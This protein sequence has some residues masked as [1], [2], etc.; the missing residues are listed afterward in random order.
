MTAVGPCAARARTPGRA[1][2]A[3]RPC[4]P[5]RRGTGARGTGPGRARA[6]CTGRADRSSAPRGTAAAD[7]PHR[8]STRQ[9]RRRSPRGAVR[10]CPAAGQLVVVH[11]ESAR[12]AEA[13]RQDE[14]RDERGRRD[15]RPPARRSASTGLAAD[16]VPRV[17]V[18]AVAR[19][20]QA[21]HHRRVRR[22][23][24]GH[25]RVRLAEPRVRGPR[26]ALNAGV[27]TPDGLRADGVGPCR[28]ERDEQDRRAGRGAR[29]ALGEAAPA[30]DCT[31]RGRSP[32]RPAAAPAAWQPRLGSV[33]PAISRRPAPPSSAAGTRRAVA[34]VAE[35]LPGDAPQRQ[36][37]NGRFGGGTCPLQSTDVTSSPS[38][39]QRTV[40]RTVI[41]AMSPRLTFDCRVSI[42]KAA[43]T[44]SRR[45][46]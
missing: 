44:S 22:Q 1:A 38:T 42:Q 25:R 5:P 46:H 34:A 2:R 14:R 29:R 45:A 3:A 36:S 37:V 7:R 15:S 33:A 13:P 30:R 26:R 28:I 32:A 11:V 43:L 20:V 39:M 23:R 12:E 17:L 4:R 41:F 9:A 40:R 35:R 8:R 6:A 31:T 27:L 19:R 18:N 10:S 24:L 21:R 16:S